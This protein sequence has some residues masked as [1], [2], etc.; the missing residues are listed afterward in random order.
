MRRPLGLVVLRRAEQPRLPPE[1]REPDRMQ[2]RRQRR[3]GARAS[4]ITVAVPTALSVAPD[5]VYTPSMYA[6]MSTTPRSSSPRL[7]PISPTATGT[8]R[9][10]MSTSTMTRRTTLGPTPGWTFE[11]AAAC[12]MLSPTA[13]LNHARAVDIRSGVG[14]GN[15]EPAHILCTGPEGQGSI[16]IGGAHM[17]AVDDVDGGASG[18]GEHE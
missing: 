12:L 13:S 1:G 14:E 15:V 3:F 2:W 4:S 5:P 11:L 6:P 9:V 8:S 10:L 16:V 7:P 17:H 18:I